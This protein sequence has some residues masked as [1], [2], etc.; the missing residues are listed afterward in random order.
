MT[1][2]ERHTGLQH[3]DQALVSPVHVPNMLLRAMQ[4]D[5][6]L[7]SLKVLPDRVVVPGNS[8]EAVTVPS[9]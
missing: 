6:A 3:K 7:R 2:I 4:A 9:L 5:E 8:Q 1:P